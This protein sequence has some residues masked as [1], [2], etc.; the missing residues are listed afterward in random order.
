ML[1]LVSTPIGN[2][3]DFSAR[4][5]QVL[6]SADL[7]ACEDTRSGRR[8]FSLLG[9]RV[10]AVTS[11][12][13]HNGAAAR[14]KLI[15]KLKKG[16]HIALISDAG[17]PLI[18]DPGYKLVRECQK[19]GIPVTAVPG[20]NAVLPALQ[21]SGLPTDAFLFAGF[22]PARQAARKQTFMKYQSTPATL[23]FYETA[24]RLIE[25]LEDMLA[26][27]G[28]RETAV[29]R[30]ITKKFEEVRRDSVQNLIQHYR[31]AG[32][33]KGEIALVVSR[34]GENKVREDSVDALVQNALKTRSVRDTVAFVAK[35]ANRPKKEIYK[36]A[37][38]FSK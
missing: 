26:V 21:L 16:A 20:A 14:P 32:S 13:E 24:G 37:L 30:E 25:S 9:L 34:G 35:T 11:Y 18:S 8:L 36:K 23:I 2:L 19:N 31:G 5:K 27:L 7:V 12:H 15:A 33:P 22:L 6:E 4:G 38:E 28:N 1:Y 17:T 10:R 29:V 3:G